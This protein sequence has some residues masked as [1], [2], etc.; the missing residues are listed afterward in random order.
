MRWTSKSCRRLANACEEQGYSV[1]R[2]LVGKPFAQFGYTLQ[3]NAKTREGT[4]PPDRDGQFETI[5]SRA[6][7]FLAGRKPVIPV[8]T[9][10][11]E[12]VRDFRNGGREWR[13]G[14]GPRRSLSMTSP[15]RS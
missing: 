7:D 5:N 10:K 2:T 6:A 14:T 15:T 8:D 1:S 9:R 11:K 3:G 4:D 13:P 12:P